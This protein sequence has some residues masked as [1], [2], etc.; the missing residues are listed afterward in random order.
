MHEIAEHEVE[1][2]IKKLDTGINAEDSFRQL[3]TRLV[4]K[5][6]HLPTERLRRAGFEG[7]QDVLKL[8]SYLF[9]D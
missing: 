7:Q 8:A 9:D 6:M 5:A 3:A 1:R 4:N 2:A